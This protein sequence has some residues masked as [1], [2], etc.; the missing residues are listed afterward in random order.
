MHCTS[1]PH[2]GPAKPITRRDIL[3][4]P[5]LIAE[6]TPAEEQIVLNWM[7]D[8]HRLKLRLPPDKYEAWTQDL[9]RIRTSRVA[10]YEGIDSLVGK[11]NHAAFLI[12]LP[13]HFLSRFRDLIN[14][15]KSQRQLITLSAICRK[16]F[17][18]V[19]SG[20]SPLQTKM[21]KTHIYR[22]KSS[23]NHSI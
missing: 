13:H 1:C 11:L 4:G 3:S 22:T 20:Q 21:C 6:G 16:L 8:T 9:I 10:T 23:A 7:I 14:R 12:P 2:A 19:V 18:N 17:G 15:D 5:K